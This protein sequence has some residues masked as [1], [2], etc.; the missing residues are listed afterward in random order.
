MSLH[1]LK[2]IPPIL[3][4]LKLPNLTSLEVGGRISVSRTY[5]ILPITS[6]EEHLP[7]FTELPEMEVCRRGDSSR[8]TFQAPSQA[9]LEYFPCTRPVGK[10]SYHNDR[11]LWGN[12]PLHSVRKLIVIVYGSE[13]GVAGAWLVNP[14]RDLRSLEDL[15]LRGCCGYLI[16]YLRR[17]VM[18]GD[19]LPGI[20]TL[21]VRSG[22]RYEIRQALR[23]ENVV[24]GLDLGI[25][26]TCIQDPEIADDSEMIDGIYDELWDLEADGASESWGWSDEVKS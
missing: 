11:F 14:L 15:E 23:L 10:A 4:F 21:I 12:L 1:C 6:F 9:A 5:P 7:N 19:Y 25:S 26:V 18:R 8:V 17:M 3:R 22:Y 16:R 2:E 13:A 24:D 20:K